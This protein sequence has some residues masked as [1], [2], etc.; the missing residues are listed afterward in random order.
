MKRWS[1]QY[2]RLLRSLGPSCWTSCGRGT[3]ESRPCRT[4]S[5][6]WWEAGQWRETSQ[7]SSSSLDWLMLT[8]RLSLHYQTLGESEVRSS[9]SSWS[10]AMSR[11]SSSRPFSVS[12]SP[13]LKPTTKLNRFNKIM[14][15]GISS[16]NLRF[17]TFGERNSFSSYAWC[18]ERTVLWS[19]LSLFPQERRL[20]QS[21]WY[22]LDRTDIS[23]MVMA[24]TFVLPKMEL[25]QLP[26]AS[27]M[28]TPDLIISFSSQKTALE[29]EKCY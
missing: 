23:F 29:L 26:E 11:F 6:S 2:W 21:S 15:Q 28:T 7:F 10:S 5:W 18:L 20:R 12:F 1:P 22:R 4:F 25:M 16:S 24:H 14:N 3:W 8:S 13:Q 17:S 9:P 19:E 27:R